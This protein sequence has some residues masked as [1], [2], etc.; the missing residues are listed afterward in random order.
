MLKAADELVIIAYLNYRK[1]QNLGFL[2]YSNLCSVF[3]YVLNNYDK[4]Y[5]RKIF[6]KLVRNNHFEKKRNV[7]R[8]YTY[9]YV[10][11]EIT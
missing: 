7:K 5:I 1:Y 6:I 2:K 11:T 4:N 9:K 10:P 8:S 3:C